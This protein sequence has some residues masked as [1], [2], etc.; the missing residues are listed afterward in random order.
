MLFA[1]CFC[2]P[3]TSC[4]IHVRSR[5]SNK[6]AAL[7]IQVA[8][9]FLKLVWYV[10]EE[11]ILATSAICQI[12]ATAWIKSLFPA[13]APWR[14]SSSLPDAAV[15]SLWQTEKHKQWDAHKVET[16]EN[17]PPHQDSLLI[18]KVWVIYSLSAFLLPSWSNEL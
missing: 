1:S 7:D 14:Y 3:L 10:S 6:R 5:C 12:D 15:I 2:K 17:R 13:M 16:G 18:S 4:A 9:F 8:T 11:Q